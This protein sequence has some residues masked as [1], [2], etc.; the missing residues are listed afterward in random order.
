MQEEDAER[1]S[2]FD[3]NGLSQCTTTVKGKIQRLLMGSG[4]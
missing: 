4:I 3:G 2:C 1:K